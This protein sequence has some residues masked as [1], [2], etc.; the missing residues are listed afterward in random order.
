MKQY[1]QYG[2]M[3]AKKTQRQKNKYIIEKEQQFLTNSTP[4]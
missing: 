2:A 3:I 1:Q 4:N